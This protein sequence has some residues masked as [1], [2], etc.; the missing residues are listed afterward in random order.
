VRYA[1]EIGV[2]RGNGH[3]NMKFIATVF[4][5]LA[6]AYCAFAPNS[7]EAARKAAKPKS[8]AAAQRSAAGAPR[9]VYAAMPE[10][11]RMAI[12]SDLIWTGDYDGIVGAEFG[13]RAIAAVKAFQKRNAG[14]ETGILNPD[15]HAKL[16]Q[17][18]KS[19]QAN[20]GWRM[21]DDR[22][23]GAQLGVPGKLVP[24][25]AQATAGSR[26][27]SSRG[28]VQ[29]E[30]FRVAA[31]DTTLAAVFA[32][33]KTE[34]SNRKVEYQVLKPDFFVLSGIQGGVKKFY[35]RAQAR[36]NDV[37]G[38]TILY[39]QATE[40]IMEPIV[41]AIS[42][43]FVAFPSAQTAGQ[44]GPAPRRQVEYGSGIVVSSAGHI[45]THRQV[46]DDCQVV[47]IP[48]IGNAERVAEDK[49]LDLALLRVYGA[50]DLV[51]AV[52]GES[53]R[54]SDVTLIGVADPQAQNG[55]AT[56]SSVKARVL[57]ASGSA[58][59]IEPAPAQ[60]F[61]GSAAIDQEARLLGMV[62][63]KPQA[64]TAATQAV[65]VPADAVRM[66]LDAHNIAPASGGASLD[67]AKASVV[68][69]I[70]VRK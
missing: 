8:A 26:W 12:Q 30:T 11:D 47:V 54:G 17:S 46:I 66:F 59:P 57:A 37:R 6:A 58:R 32:R 67:G 5:V 39:D 10:A 70:C 69:V 38:V 34:P 62:G 68:R 43:A 50:R 65:I 2:L 51:P 21:V 16:A 3:G 48:G 19:R 64:G 63:L 49:V 20:A 28:E 41:I 4:I 15:E 36:D 29:V 27:Q 53:G 22:A 18:A 23:T 25:S 14:R 24:Q 45:V 60:G 55:G 44:S 7:A 42:N 13:D 61:S 40:G 33:L 1:R 35:V 52:F 56:V 31:R 9:A